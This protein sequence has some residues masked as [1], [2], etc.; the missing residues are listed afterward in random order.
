MIG[1]SELNTPGRILIVDDDPKNRE[2]LRDLLEV[3]GYSVLEAEDGV[4]AL[5]KVA[6]SACDV[7]LLDVMMPRMDGL[8]VCRQLKANPATAPIPVLMV[9]ALAEKEER[10]QGIAAGANDYL[11]KPVER[12]DVLLRV[13]NALYAKRLYDQVQ[14]EGEAKFQLLA[15]TIKDVFWISSPAIDRIFYVSPAYETVWGLPCASLYQKPLSFA[16]AIYPKDKARVMAAVR[17]HAQGHWAVEYRIIRPDGTLRWIQDRGFPVRDE[18]GELLQMCGVARDITEQKE[19]EEALRKLSAQLNR[20]EEDVR[21]R[22]ARELHDS[23]GQKLAALAMTV[24]WLQESKGVSEGKTTKMFADCLGMIEQCTQEIRTLS[25]LLHPPLLDELGLAAAIGEYIEGFSKRSGMRVSLDV[26]TDLERLPDE[27]E[28]T[29]FRIVQES[30]GNIHRY[31]G[32]SAA[33]IGLVCDV[34]RVVL[35]VRDLGCGMTAERLH[36]IELGRCSDGVGIAGMR[37]RLRLVGGRLEIESGGQGT[38][39]RAVIPL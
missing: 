13:R 39:V 8:E 17:G 33:R 29:L 32:D 2:L 7:I 16:E 36:A 12:Q 10:L 22:I 6:A 27:V 1:K 15:E 14:R 24:G 26:P 28:I 21:R 9:T 35:E 23:T 20:A 5:A 18:R 37:E 31:A 4:D 30:L 11:M 3:N 25:F 34:E 19:S 38:T